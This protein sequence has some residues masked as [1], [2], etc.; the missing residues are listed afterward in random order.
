MSPPPAAPNFGAQSQPQPPQNGYGQ[1]QNHHSFLPAQSVGKKLKGLAV[2]AL[3]VGIVAFLIGLVPVL[4]LLVGFVAIVFGVLALSKGQSRPM[5]VVGIVLAS[6]AVVASIG[7]TIGLGGSGDA[8][9]PVAAVATTEATAAAEVEAVVEVPAEPV[10][11][12][13][14]VTPTQAPAEPVPADAYGG[15]PDQQLSFV[16]V[17]DQHL[18]AYDA[19]STEL[20]E[21]EA[22]RSRDAA[23][24]ET[25]PGGA[26]QQ[27]VGKIIEIGANDEGKAH[28]RIEIAEN[29][30]FQTWNNAFSD[31]GDNTLIEPGTPMFT[32]LTSM[33]E[34]QLVTF[35]GTLLTGTDSCLKKANLTDAFYA[36]DPN[37]LMVFSDIRAQ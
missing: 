14:A 36:V 26:T 35:S 17:A 22:I 19:A 7:T 30:V 15:Y 4:G 29:M 6:L 11:A 33:E 32:A 2:T 27:W 9:E 23:L 8:D 28:V 25:V 16:T 3:V 21:S 37:W 24:C 5:A 10:E 20:Q 31:I 18:D 13:P 1:Q 12:A 34:G